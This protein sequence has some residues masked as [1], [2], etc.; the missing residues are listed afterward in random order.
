MVYRTTPR[1]SERK[2]AR[3]RAFLTAAT[4]LFGR[5]GYHATTVPMIVADAGASTGSFYFYFRNK[6]DVFASVLNDVGERVTSAINASL[7]QTGPEPLAQMKAAVEGFVHFLSQHADVARILIVESSGLSARLEQLRRSVIASHS[8]GVEN[9]L[10]LLAPELPAV[11]ATITAR[12]WV[13]AVYEAAYSWLE[14]PKDERPP[15]N[16]LAE[17]VARFNLRGIGAS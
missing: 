5:L 13:G 15:A 12:C 3:R 9:A 2:D 17:T 1:M 4:R 10:R 11:D 6:E 7:A 14:L 8:R 16:V